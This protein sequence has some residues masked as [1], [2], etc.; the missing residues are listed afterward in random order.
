MIFT[1]YTDPITIQRLSQSSDKSSYGAVSGTIYGLFM[2]V[3][4]DQNIIA[5][6]ITGQAYKFTTDAAN[7]VRTGDI[8]TYLSEEYAVKGTQKFTQKSIKILYC[9]LEKRQK[10]S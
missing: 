6:R 4:S 7:D 8:V 3:D 1:S 2:P 5:L 9:F 10:Y